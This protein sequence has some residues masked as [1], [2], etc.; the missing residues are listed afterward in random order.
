MPHLDA[1]LSRFLQWPLNAVLHKKLSLQL[2]CRKYCTIKDGTQT[3]DFIAD[4]SCL[5]F[6]TKNIGEMYKII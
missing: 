5:L 6:L 4:K 2:F 3:Y 1:M